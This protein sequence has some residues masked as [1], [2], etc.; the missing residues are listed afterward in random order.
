MQFE[1][2]PFEIK[3]KGFPAKKGVLLEKEGRYSEVSPLPGRSIETYQDALEQLHA[4][5][6]GWRGPLFPSVEFG[7]Y[8]LIAPLAA[9]VPCA[10]FLYGTPDEVLKTAETAHGCTVAKLKV[11]HWTMDEA[12]AVIRALPFKL[13]LDFNHLWESAKV[14]QLCAKLSPD[15]IEFLE[16]AGSSVPGFIEAVDERES[17]TIWKPMVRGLPSPRE[18]LILS[19]SFES[20]IGLHQ[21]AS[22]IQ[23][24][25]I[26]P[27]VLGIGTITHLEQDLVQNPAVLKDGKLHF[28]TSWILC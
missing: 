14:H 6:K 1:I 2:E 9:S 22:L 12:L 13:R 11:G 15:Q 26:P 28:P 27:H 7:I 17:P 8:G 21:I 24:H 20:S 25:Q 5:K 19:S 16:D 3:L 18:H 4:V 10:L 23:S